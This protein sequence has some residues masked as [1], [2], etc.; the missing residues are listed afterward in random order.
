MGES[1]QAVTLPGSTKLSTGAPGVGG[2]AITAGAAS[3]WVR[4]A[5]TVAADLRLATPK[6]A[7][8]A[9]TRTTTATPARA[10]RGEMGFCSGAVSWL[11]AGCGF[12][13]GLLVIRR[14]EEHTSELQSLRPSRMPS[15]A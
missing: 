1:V 3:S 2:A 15:S 5:R 14:S 11:L 7:R 4:F 6:T 10:R 8:A 12:G 9:V 13:S